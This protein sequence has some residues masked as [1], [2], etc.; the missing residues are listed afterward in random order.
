VMGSG[1]P[2]GADTSDNLAIAAIMTDG[3]RVDDFNTTNTLNENGKTIIKYMPG[4]LLDVKN[5]RAVDINGTTID[6]KQ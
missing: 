6:F 5:V 2:H 4:S 1:K 3:K